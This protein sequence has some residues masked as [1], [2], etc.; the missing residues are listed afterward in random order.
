LGAKKF[1]TPFGIAPF[2]IIPK[3]V[4]PQKNGHPFFAA[5]IRRNIAQN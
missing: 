1:I 4:M 3:G 5:W 2:G